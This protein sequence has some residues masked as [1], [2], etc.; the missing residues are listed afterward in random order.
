MTV[1]TSRQETSLVIIKPDAIARHF[2]GEIIARFERK[3]LQIVGLKMMQLPR[4]QVEAQYAPHKGKPFHEPLVRYMSENPVIP[5]AVRGKDA[6]RIVRAM[7]G[8]TFGSQADP[9]TI[10]GDLG[11]SN[12]FNLIH[13]S[14]SPDS[15]GREL[16]LFFKPEELFANEPSDLGWVYDLS[17]GEMV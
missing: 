7:I 6:V 3:G 16:A 9:G 15:A 10:R 12:R 2:I 1:D 13:A 11:V 5:M 8:A 4:E 17:T 14:D